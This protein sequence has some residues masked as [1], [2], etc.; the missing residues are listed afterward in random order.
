LRNVW[1]MSFD[2]ATGEFWAGDVGQDRWE[3][4][5]R[6][7]RGGNYGWRIREGAHP[8]HNQRARSALID[9]VIEYGRDDGACVTG[10]YVYRGTRLPSLVGA[11]VY[12]D[13]IT[14]RLWALR[15]ANDAVVAHREILSQ[16]KN[17][18]SFGEDTAGEL[19]ICAFDGHIYRL[20]E[21]PAGR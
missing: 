13:Y 1:R 6:I 7:V 3:E 5:D 11:Y 17:I 18:A 19:Y 12:G 8:F 9:P 4:I 14:G 20:E 15:A 10:G 21:V 16:P 2:R